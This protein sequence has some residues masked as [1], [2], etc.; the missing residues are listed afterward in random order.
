MLQ[1]K[2]SNGTQKS[3]TSHVTAHYPAKTLEVLGLLVAHGN[4]T[5]GKSVSVKITN[6]APDDDDDDGGSSDDDV[7]ERK[8]PERGVLV[9]TSAI[10]AATHQD[11]RR[12]THADEDVD[13]GTA[14]PTDDSP[15]KYITMRGNNEPRFC[16][17]WPVDI[18]F[19]GE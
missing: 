9:T 4:Q 16:R 1:R 2:T 11:Q 5:S 6:F 14:S 3:F 18:W 17:P 12:N 7:D 19:I 10:G 15:N 8:Q 13:D